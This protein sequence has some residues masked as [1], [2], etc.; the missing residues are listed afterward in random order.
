MSVSYE[1]RKKNRRL[2][3][4]AEKYKTLSKSIRKRLNER[5]TIIDKPQLTKKF[6][7]NEHSRI[8]AVLT[9]PSR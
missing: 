1:K 2:L 5:L 7:D 8:K 3:A 4:K 6:L 9:K